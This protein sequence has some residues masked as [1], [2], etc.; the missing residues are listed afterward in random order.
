M[1]VAV[2]EE[3]S[4]LR[5]QAR[6][7]PC[8]RPSVPLMRSTFIIAHDRS[9]PYSKTKTWKLVEDQAAAAEAAGTAA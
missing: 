5:A 1:R 2:T 3:L 7:A 8:C 9:G 4:P 6:A